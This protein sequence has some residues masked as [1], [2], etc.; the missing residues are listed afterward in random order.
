MENGE[1][2]PVIDIYETTNTTELIEQNENVVVPQPSSVLNVSESLFVL[3]S[4]SQTNLSQSVEVPPLT[5]LNKIIDVDIERI[6]ITQQIYDTVRKYNKTCYI[7]CELDHNM[8]DLPLS[9]MDEM[10]KENN[11]ERPPVQVTSN[12]RGFYYIVNGRHRIARALILEH[13]TITVEIIDNHTQKSGKVDYI[14]SGGESN[15]GLVLRK[16]NN[17]INNNI[18]K[19]VSLSSI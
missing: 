13:I 4:E 10:M 2:M 18:T 9:R 19:N 16:M 11:I 15:P 5:S 8:S 12:D 14:I 1:S 7:D 6:F 3:A 17:Y